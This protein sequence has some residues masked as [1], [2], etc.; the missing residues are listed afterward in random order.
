MSQ[1]LRYTCVAILAAVV[2]LGARSAP[3]QFPV[4]RSVGLKVELTRPEIPAG[5]TPAFRL[6]LRNEG[7][8]PLL[9]NG[10]SMLGNGK[11]IWSSIACAFR[12]PAGEELPLHLH[13]RVAAVGG[14]I[15]FLG[16]PLRSGDEHSILV[17]PGDYYVQVGTPLAAGTYEL[18]CSYRG[19]QSEYRDRT[20]LPLCW[21]GYAVA[22]PVTF[23]VRGAIM[24]DVSAVDGITDPQA[25][26]ASHPTVAFARE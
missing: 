12:N 4:A 13:W 24:E 11:Q 26:S 9:L 8:D 14:R 5:E 10:G 1:H 19:Q 22:P 21:E 17:S 16:L 15:Y 20:Q 18:R 3:R 2:S 6:L 7:A 23:E 25:D